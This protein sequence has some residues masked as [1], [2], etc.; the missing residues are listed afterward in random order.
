MTARI[1][2]AFIIAGLTA[3]IL[4]ALEPVKRHHLYYC[5]HPFSGYAMPCMY[6]KNDPVP[7]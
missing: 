4:T 1:A 5:V 7:V 2:L 6:R 3:T